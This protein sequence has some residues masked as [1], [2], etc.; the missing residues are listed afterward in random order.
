MA[1]SVEMTPTA[2][3]ELRSSFQY[4]HARAP[5]NA[6]R[7]LKGIYDAIGSLEEFPNRCAIAPE[8]QHLG[9]TVRHQLFKSHRIIFFVDEPSHS[10]KILYIR[11][12]KMRTVGESRIDKE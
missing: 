2:E 8:S 5:R 9:E 6:V 10:V 4:I 12:A 11:H 1:Y 7:W 3:R